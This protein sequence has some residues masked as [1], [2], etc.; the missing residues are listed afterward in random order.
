MRKFIATALLAAT[1]VPVAASAQSND[2]L[3]RDRQDIRRDQRDLR[4][5]RHEYRE[6]VRDR[7]RAW[8]RD[9]WRGWRDRNPNWYARGR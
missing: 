5:A 6:D 8:G 9:D 2:E 3:R 7:E 1:L 4:D